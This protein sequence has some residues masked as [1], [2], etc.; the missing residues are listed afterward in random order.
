MPGQ[1]LLYNRTVGSAPTK[2]VPTKHM[3]EHGGAPSQQPMAGHGLR[4]TCI[5]WLLPQKHDWKRKCDKPTNHGKSRFAPHLHNADFEGKMQ[6]L[7]MSQCTWAGS[8]PA[9]LSNRTSRLYNLP[10]SLLLHSCHEFRHL[11]AR[12]IH[13]LDSLGHLCWRSF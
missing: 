1:S 2:S 3:S 13:I 10:F 8:E 12:S 11:T 4:Y 6:Q 7:D 9:N 5:M